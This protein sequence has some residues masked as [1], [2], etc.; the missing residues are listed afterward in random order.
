[1]NGDR[2]A[3]EPGGRAPAPEPLRLVQRFVNSNDR[4]GGRDDFVTPPALARWFHGAGLRVGRLDAR[5]LERV[6]KLREAL[7]ALL[8]ANN[9]RP[10]D[11]RAL[12]ALDNEAAQSGV[13][14]RFT[15]TTPALAPGSSGLDRAVGQLLAAVFAAMV[16]GTWPRLKACRRDVCQWAFY[17]HSKNRS[18]TWC[19]MDV[20]GNRMKTSSY[21]RRTH[22][23]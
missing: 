9:G 4:E 2:A 10:V 8:L 21:W 1:M 12:A 11:P 16:D 7:R 18:G 20:C 3:R 5:D 6:L 23:R 22:P 19:T 13:A 14:L 15:A 17:D